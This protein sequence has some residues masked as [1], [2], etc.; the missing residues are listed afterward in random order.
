MCSSSTV[1]PGTGRS[2]QVASYIN[3]DKNVFAAI[4]MA[5]QDNASTHN[6]PEHQTV[7]L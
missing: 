6:I 1:V 3:T 4:Y 7:T 5:W 2:Q